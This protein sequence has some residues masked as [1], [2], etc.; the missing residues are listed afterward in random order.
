MVV[1]NSP[2]FQRSSAPSVVEPGGLHTVG[3]GVKI[4]VDAIEQL[5]EIGLNN[6]V[7]LPELVLVGDQSAGK[8][9]LMGALAEI[10]LPKS[11]GTC[12]RCPAHIK[13]ATAAQWSCKISLRQEYRYSSGFIILKGYH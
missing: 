1:H 9:S 11:G 8:S 13:T 3:R 5:R 10:H 6:V 2:C 12:T 7:Q 4:F